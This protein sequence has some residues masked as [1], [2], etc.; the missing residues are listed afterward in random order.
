MLTPAFPTSRPRCGRWG[1]VGGSAVPGVVLIR[2]D[3]HLVLGVRWS[4]FQVS[5]AGAGTTLTAGAQARLFIV[6]PPQHVGE[7]S[8]PPGSAAPQQLPSGAG[9]TVPAWRGVLSGPTRLTFQVPAGKQIPLTAEGVLAAVVDNPLVAS[10]DIPGPDDTAI[11]LPWRLVIAPRGRS[12]GTVVCRHQIR[13]ASA[14]SSGMWRTRLADPASATDT[15]DADLDIKVVDKATAG[16][17]DP[18]F[19]ENRTTRFRSQDTTAQRLFLTTR[20]QPARATRLELSPLGGTLDAVGR[21]PNFEWDHR[22]VLGRDMHV[23]TLAKGVMY[24]F[25]HRAEFLQIA[26]RIYDPAAGGAAVLR[27][28]CVCSPSSNPC[29]RHRVR[30]SSAARSRSV[31]SR[32]PARCSPTWPIPFGW[33]P[34]D[35][36]RNRWAPTSGRKPSPARKC[37]SPLPVAP[38]PACSNSPCRCCSW[39]TWPPTSRHWPVPTSPNSWRTSTPKPRFASQPPTSTWS[40]EQPARSARR[41]PPRKRATSRKS[42]HSKSPGSRSRSGLSLADG[43]RSKLTELEIGLPALRSLLGEDPRTRAKFAPRVPAERRRGRTAGDG[44]G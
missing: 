22:A 10:P 29:A 31:T 32:S 24:P 33:P 8:S 36:G 7:E 6:L 20:N 21:F 28:D 34:V 13:L 9:A 15:V 26:E 5:G 11:E 37:S 43:Y 30:G 39:T 12:S 38:P 18:T 27:S 2:A 35:P 42:G 1:W 14:E 40:G 4:G 19:D 23:R 41:P 16:A 25:G 3:D 44:Q 17:A